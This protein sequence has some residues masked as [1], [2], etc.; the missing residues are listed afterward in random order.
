MAGI[1][2]MGTRAAV[3]LD[4]TMPHVPGLWEAYLRH[5]VSSEIRTRADRS[6]TTA[7]LRLCDRREP[8]AHRAT[9]TIVRV[10]ALP[11]FGRQQID[12]DR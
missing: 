12:K 8:W 9:R 11:E 10:F 4:Q 7:T 3:H 6:E 5:R 1:R 2:T